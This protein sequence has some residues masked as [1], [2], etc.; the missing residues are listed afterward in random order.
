VNKPKKRKKYRVVGVQY[1]KTMDVY[2]ARIEKAMNELTD[3]GYTV[4]LQDQDD[5]IT[6]V[7]VDQGEN[8]F[9]AFMAQMRVSG[10][11]PHALRLSDRSGALLDRFFEA[12]D[13]TDPK[14]FMEAVN[15]KLPGLVHGFSVEELTTA[16]DEYAR[17]AEGHDKGHDGDEACSL[18]EI[19]RQLSGLLKTAAR[20][21]LQ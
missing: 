2:A 5:G 7:G 6:I 18:G 11:H 15:K 4:Q 3:D 10:A 16:S 1:S 14:A 12:S 20:A 9:A 17:E 19:L 13:S 21:N 8:P